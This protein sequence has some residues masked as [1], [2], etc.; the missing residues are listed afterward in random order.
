M[1]ISP[2]CS[3]WI[4]DDL[5]QFT[6]YLVT[7]YRTS[8]SQLEDIFAE[9]KSTYNRG[10]ICDMT[11]LWL[12]INDNK[13]VYFNTAVKKELGAIIDHA[14]SVPDNGKRNEYIV[15]KL[16]GCKVV[17][18]R[19]GIPYFKTKDDG[20]EVPVVV[21]HCLGG[22]KNYMSYFSFKK[23][24]ILILFMHRVFS[25]LSGKCDYYIS[26]IYYPDDYRIWRTVC[27]EHRPKGKS[28]IGLLSKKDFALDTR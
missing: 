27:V 23:N 16:A 20:K 18:F 1:A 14:I 25:K 9:Y 17:K 19:E 3:L 7:Y 15:S 4:I 21:L 26:R 10:G 11:F 2:R 5:E 22:Y 28:K 24:N 6:N 8:V 13:L 12:W